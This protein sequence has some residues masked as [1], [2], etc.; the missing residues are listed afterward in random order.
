MGVKEYLKEKAK[1]GWQSFKKRVL[2][3]VAEDVDE[4]AEEIKEE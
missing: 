2:K 1:Q 4:K 3:E